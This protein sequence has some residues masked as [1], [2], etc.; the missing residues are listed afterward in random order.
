[1]IVDSIRRCQCQAGGQDDMEAARCGGRVL[2]A[3]DSLLFGVF[4]SMANL[5][6]LSFSKRLR[7]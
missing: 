3:W 4:R 5:V 7:S 2:G 1:M 6:A